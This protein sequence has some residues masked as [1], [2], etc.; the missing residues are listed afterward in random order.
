[1]AA[2]ERFD[3]VLM[4]M[5]MPV[6]DGIEASLNIRQAG[7]NRATPIIALTANAMDSH[8]ETWLAAGVDVF[9]TKPIDPT[10]LVAALLDACTGERNASPEAGTAVA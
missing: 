3:A 7:I 10:A 5:Q 1:M 6:M 8:R 2:V 9:L 4:D